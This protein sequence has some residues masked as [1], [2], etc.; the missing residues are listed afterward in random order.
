L[1]AAMIAVVL[2][3]SPGWEWMVTSLLAAPASRAWYQRRRPAIERAFGTVLLIA[4]FKLP[5]AT[6]DGLRTII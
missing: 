5:G 6:W 3:V 2:A 4:S 1:I